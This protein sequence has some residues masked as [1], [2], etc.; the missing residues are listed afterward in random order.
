MLSLACFAVGAASTG[1]NSEHPKPSMLAYALDSDAGKALWASS[2]ARVDSWTAQFVGA[3]PAKEKLPGYY[4]DWIT[5]KFLQNEAPVLPL[6]PPEVRLV[7]STVAGDT[8]TLLLRVTSPRHAR[9]LSLAAPDNEIAESWV[10]GRKLGDP[11]QARFNPGGKWKLSYANVPADGIELKLVVKG[12][13]TLKLRVI[14][15][16]PG[17]PE[18]P[19]KTF[20][21]RPAEAMPYHSGD[22]TFV[23][24][25]FVF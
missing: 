18:I 1:Y 25:S 22:S 14:D 16:S 24:R 17:L 21:L 23:R 13:A 9:S 4:P 19:G 20:A 6:A 10:N 5:R 15:Q 3:S 7:E 8:R 11:K 12:A 2:A